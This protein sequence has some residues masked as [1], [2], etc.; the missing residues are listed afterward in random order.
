MISS[1]RPRNN[2]LSLQRLILSTPNRHHTAMLLRTLAPAFLALAT[3]S[4]VHADWPQYRGP[5][6]DGSSPDK[7]SAWPA[8]G[9]KVLWKVE[10]PNGFSSFA[11]GGGKAFTIEGR[12]P[13]GVRQEVLVARDAAT[14]KE[15]WAQPLCVA[16]YGHDGGNSGAKDNK[17]GD[18][19]RSTPTLV[20]NTVVTMSAA[21]GLQAFDAAT[22]KSLW[23]RDL[24]KENGGRNITWQNAASPLVEGG[25]LYVAGGGTDQ[26]I[27]AIDPANGNVVAKAFDE[28]MTHSTPTAATIL[29]D[30]QIIFFLQ[31]GL[32]AVEPKTLRELWRY[33]FPYSTSTAISP[34]VSG[35]IVYCSAGYGVGAGAVKLAE[36]GVEWSVQE[37]YRVPGNNELANHW[38]TPVLKNG[39]LFGM[40]QFKNYGDGPV[41][42]VDIATGT[43]KWEQPGF[44]PGNV[45]LVGDNVLALSDA[46][47]LVL[48][49][50]DPAGYKELGRTKVLEGKCWTTPVISDGRV[51]AR[52][53][54]EAVCLDIS[55]K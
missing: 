48:F 36:N 6:G 5:Q 49:A 10:S 15:L 8:S 27:L 17:G 31:S 47:E 1:S 52:S 34:V 4:S 42:C 53:T 39:H 2:F 38:S 26:S 44:G 33:K 51:Y 13:D 50:A 20:G 43:I 18:G 28:K 30:R 46:G 32:L 35:D 29:G 22:G 54:K 9:L 25:L 12:D 16:N 55:G 3:L 41:K 21:L 19:P 40:F 45:V 11:V 23:T 14:G 37:I 7:I 24:M